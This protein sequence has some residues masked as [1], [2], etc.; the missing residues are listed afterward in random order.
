MKEIRVLAAEA[1]HNRACNDVGGNDLENL[2]SR[3]VDVNGSGK[4]PAH[5]VH[6]EPDSEIGEDEEDEVK[7]QFHD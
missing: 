6:G 3:A 1:C 4:V 7:D 5:A 2:E